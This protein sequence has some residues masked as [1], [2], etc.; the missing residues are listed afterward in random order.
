MHHLV[1]PAFIFL[2]KINSYFIST[3]QLLSIQA[4]KLTLGNHMSQ[5]NIS[6]VL[7]HQPQDNII[8]ANELEKW[9]LDGLFN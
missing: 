4:T 9:H 1:N 6:A 3:E 2:F 7:S 5:L 8:T